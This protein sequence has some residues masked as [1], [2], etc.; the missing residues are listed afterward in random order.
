[1]I[2]YKLFYLQIDLDD[3]LPT[4]ICPPCYEKVETFL[5][6]YN[7][8]KSNQAWFRKKAKERE[9]VKELPIQEEEDEM[10]DTDDEE[11]ESKE[12]ITEEPPVISKRMT[13]SRGDQQIREFLK[14]TCEICLDASIFESFKH[15]Q[16]H[17]Q[18]MHNCKGYV[19]CCKRKFFRKDRL[20]SHIINHVNPDAF[21]YVLIAI[22]S[23]YVLII[24]SR[25]CPEC[26][27][28][29]KSKVLLGIHMKQ[30]QNEKPF[31]CQKCDQRFVLRSQLTNHVASHLSDGEKKYIC[32]VCD[33]AFALKF[34][35]TKHKETHTKQKKFVCEICAKGF[36]T[37]Y[38]LQVHVAQHLE[39]S[40]TKQQCEECKSW[41]KNKETL[42]TH[43]LKHRDGYRESVCP[44][45]QRKCSTKSSLSAHIRYVHEQLKKYQ[46]DICGKQFRRKLELIEHKARHSGTTLYSCPFCAKKFT[47]SSNYFSHRKNIHVAEF[48]VISNKH[49]SQK[50]DISEE[51]GCNVTSN[52]ETD[53]ETRND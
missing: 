39:V 1:M 6:Y 42:R 7:A 34:V 19:V 26:G 20:V 52:T 28:V 43:M 40:K 10:Q 21:R 11:V 17:Y 30:H 5:K 2:C 32:D 3:G 25:R 31:Q 22:Q 44:I 49:P 12:D 15:L 46:C 37:K 9:N 50:I 29:R 8:V 16:N 13:K 51:D 41:F 33:K 47:S 35:L 4:H 18:C 48:A 36:T 23:P 14:L 53:K 45:C 24:C 27:E 38:N